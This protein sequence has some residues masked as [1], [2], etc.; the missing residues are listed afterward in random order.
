M[1]RQACFSIKLEAGMIYREAGPDAR[2]LDARRPDARRPDARIGL[3]GVICPG[4]AA[5]GS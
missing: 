1:G 4:A 5:G 2:S 3:S